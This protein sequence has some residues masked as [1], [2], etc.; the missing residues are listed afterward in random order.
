[1]GSGESAKRGTGGLLKVAAIGRALTSDSCHSNASAGSDGSGAFGNC[2]CGALRAVGGSSG[3]ICAAPLDVLKVGRGEDS[4]GSRAICAP[5]WVRLRCFRLSV[6]S[7]ADV[8][9]GGGGGG[10][11]GGGLQSRCH[12]APL[13]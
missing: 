12:P 11:G 10:G 1:M 8:C 3:A 6:V 7:A 5:L 9:W 4:G 2:T 13:P